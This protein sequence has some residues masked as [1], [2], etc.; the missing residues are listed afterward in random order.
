MSNAAGFGGDRPRVVVSAGMS[1]D[2]RVT[3]RRDSLLMEDAGRIWASV[4]PP[5]AS[6]LEDLRQ[7]HLDA[8][9][10]PKAVLEGSGSLVTDDAG[11]LPGLSEPDPP[12]TEALYA[13]FLPDEILQRP[14]HDKWFAVVDGRGRVRWTQKGGS[15]G[16]DVLVLVAKATPAAYL[17]YLRRERIS[18]LV[19]GDERV[20]LTLALRRMRQRLG[21]E[22]VLSK[23]GGG[24]NG[25]LLRAGLVDEIQLIVSPTVVGGLGTPSVFDGPELAKGQA[26]TKLRL[27]SAQVETDGMLW[28][29]YDVVR[30]DR[31]E[32]M[33]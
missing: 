19:A 5:S 25:A 10:R 20:D 18:Y 3:L 30:G 21:I 13:D 14:D 27:R 12:S 33:T 1:I 32:G 26:P 15:G 11:P 31:L 24:L 28:L 17:S 9:H 23:A 22:C 2:G 6:A 7:A 4:L 8:V 29:A 16:W